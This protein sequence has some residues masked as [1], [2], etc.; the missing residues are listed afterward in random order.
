MPGIFASI[1]RHAVSPM[2]CDLRNS[3]AEAKTFDRKA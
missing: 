1:I 2:L 3:S